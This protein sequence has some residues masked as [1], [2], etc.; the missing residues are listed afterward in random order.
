MTFEKISD[1]PPNHLCNACQT[2]KPVGEMLVV[3]I[4]REKRY[5]LRPKCKPC[6]N[7]KERGHRRRQKRE[8]LRKWRKRNKELTNSYHKTEAHREKARI[9]SM[10]FYHQNR[11]VILI[12]LRFKSKR[13][14]ISTAEAKKFLKRFGR[15]YP[16]PGGLT[17]EG[18]IMC[19]RIRSRNRNRNGGRQTLSSFEIRLMV[20]D[21]G[22]FTPP[23]NT[24][25]QNTWQIEHAP[26]SASGKE[27]EAGGKKNGLN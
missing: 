14:I 7:L 15:S 22:F 3:Y 4:K 8:Y 19:E 13:I 1:M 5:K 27:K 9:S 6:H 12:K 17:K 26:D 11:D 23:P 24:G 16:K 2:V 25:E 18:R 21:D 20:Y 10:R